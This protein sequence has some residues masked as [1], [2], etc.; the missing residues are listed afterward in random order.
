M[1]VTLAAFMLKITTGNSMVSIEALYMKNL[2]TINDDLKASK[3]LDTF[4]LI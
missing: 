3:E 2:P 4:F 1:D